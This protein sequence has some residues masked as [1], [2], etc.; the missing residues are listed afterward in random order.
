MF[1]LIHST[2]QLQWCN[3]II[4]L[5]Q[6]SCT[7]FNDTFNR[8]TPFYCANQN[9]VHEHFIN[10]AWMIF[11]SLSKIGLFLKCTYFIAIFCKNNY[12]PGYPFSGLI[13]S[14]LN[15]SVEYFF[16]SHSNTSVTWQYCIKVRNFRVRDRYFGRTHQRFL[17]L[18]KR[19]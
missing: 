19:Y 3:D 4:L 13:M 11:P 2:C 6:C 15:K 8:I 10:H 17:K 18:C 16:D 5:L 14:K 12:F 7:N 1:C 9:S